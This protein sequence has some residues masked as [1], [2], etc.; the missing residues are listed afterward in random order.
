[1][2]A[3]LRYAFRTLLKT[4]RFTVMAVLVLA[5]GIGANSAMFTVVYSVLLR[6]L[7]YQDPDRVTVIL[8]SAEKTG[9][10]MP[11]T[12]GD[13]EDYHDQTRS[14]TDVAAAY[15]W[16]PT[17]T[18]KDRAEQMD[19]LRASATLFQV[20]GVKPVY[21]RL[22]SP[23]DSRADAQDTVVLTY[24]LFQRRFGGDPNLIGRTLVLDGK[25]HTVI[26]V[27]PRGFY[28]PPFWNVKAEIY[29]P[30]TFR[31]EGEGGRGPG[32]LRL[33]ARLKPGVSL[34]QARAEV[35]TI[36]SRIATAYPRASGGLTAT[37][38]PIHE[39]SVG[40]IRP[41]LLVLFGAVLFTLMIACANIANLLIARASSR[42]K[43][44]AIRQSLGA[45]RFHLIRQFLAETTV[46]AVSGGVLGLVL[47]AWVVPLFVA[48]IP[49]IGQ[50]RLPRNNEIHVTAAVLLFNF[51]I[52]LATALFCGLLTA[53]NS[54]RVDLNGSLK[55]SGRGQV[56]S[57]AGRRLRTVLATAEIAIALLLLTGAGL[58]VESY[59]NLRAVDPGFDPAG[60]LVVNV[61]LAASEH[62]DPDRRAQF[63][64][65][66]LEQF[67]ALPGVVAASA[68]NHVPLAGDRFGMQL[69][70]EGR[71]IPAPGNTPKAVYRVAM[72]GYFN[73]MR[74]RL[75]QGRDFTDRDTESAPGVVILNSTAARNFWPGENPIGKRLRRGDAQSKT[76]WL[77]VVGV[78]ADLKQ[79]DWAAAADNEA[80]YPF[81]QDSLYRHEPAS[82]A[83]MTLVVRAA[84]STGLGAAIRERIG[85]IDRN[86]SVP[87]VLAMERVIEDVT[88]QP[89][90]SMTLI[91]FFASVALILAA[92]GIYAVVS[93]VVA[94]RTQ[95]I[96]LRM[97][98]GA[99]QIDV[100][101]MI[102]WQ[103]LPPVGAGVGIGLV[104]AIALTRLMSS[105]LFG[106][107]AT[108]PFVF[109]VVALGLAVIAIMAS[110]IPARRAAR[111][112]PVIALRHE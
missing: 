89:R 73:T 104:A 72:P 1:M 42:R 33:F 76:P 32:Y 56:A 103:S 102:V 94:G 98:L 105:M 59:R 40:S 60:V 70:I 48:S 99:R 2:L 15:V 110:L 16:G 51:V 18:G 37:V 17:L 30:A 49:E 112:D 95:E 5:L 53:V 34:N 77:T 8:A 79:S 74:I 21:G 93:F 12:P 4:P 26:G 100:L 90:T 66:A 96:G 45:E 71:P 44:I 87:N 11:M 22:F 57:R 20:L 23:E 35:K 84:N 13:F 109:G 108:D 9:G 61:G 81:L 78:L 85:Q 43:E 7:P 88:W 52:C 24:D 86:I 69:T 68:V 54:G 64:A 46:L 63:Y 107:R 10:T 67:R 50:F 83:T 97:A 36:A 80:Y 28:F 91:L 6:P 47:A 55:E 41:I 92:V 106:I 3:D 29:A 111:L 82:F 101:G 39:M 25:A 38:T 19:G 75:Q 58:L 14:F 62:R 31:A 65:Q 27:T